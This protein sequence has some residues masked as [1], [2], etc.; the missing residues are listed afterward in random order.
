M[1]TYKLVWTGAAAA[2]EAASTLL[3]ETLGTPAGAVSLTRPDDAAADDAVAWRLDAYFAETPDLNAI[4]EALAEVGG[5]SAPTLETLPDID[6]V[7]HA[8][9]GLGVV[10]AGRFVLYGAHDADK[11][12][13]EPGDIAIRIDANEAF[14][15]GHHPTTAGC[16]TLL[17]RIAGVAPEKILDLGTGSAVLAIAAAKVWDRSVL[18]TDIDEKSAEIARRNVA[19]NGVGDCVQ[20]IAAD[21]F[22]HEAFGAQAPFDFIFANILA[23][24]LVALA[25][26]VASC[27]AS[28]ARVM[29]AGLMCDQEKAVADAYE[30]AGFRRL[31]RLDHPTW[32]VLLFFK[33]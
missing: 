17:D 15:T 6:W 22:D 33:P 27:A 31:N 1:K 20:V 23:G 2:L 32:P 14:G 8:L 29:L 13:D 24:P 25:P 19:I 16:L 18:A 4:R 21:G 28:K 3:M 10:R 5:L 30:A 12:P 9:A 26:A 11:L 7:A